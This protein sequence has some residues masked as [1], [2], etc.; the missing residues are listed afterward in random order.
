MKRL[1]LSDWQ[2]A[3]NRLWALGAILILFIAAC[4]DPP[5]PEDPAWFQSTTTGEALGEDI[6]SAKIN[7]VDDIF[8]IYRLKEKYLSRDGESQAV[9]KDLENRWEELLKNYTTSQTICPE[10]DLIAFDYKKVG[11]NQYR[12]DFLFKVN[13]P[14]SK[15]YKIALYGVVDENNRHLLSESRRRRGKKSEAWSSGPDPSTRDW[16]E[17]EYVFISNVIEAQPIPY[18]M[19]TILYDREGRCAHGQRVD[20]G[21]RVNLGE[22]TPDIQ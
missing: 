21:W 19:Y 5:P 17:G 11:A 8:T 6:L 3:R 1:K 10:A 15:D 14:F 7:Q 22:S 16:S 18:N 2:S 13:Q 4:S 9:A 12:A 20:L